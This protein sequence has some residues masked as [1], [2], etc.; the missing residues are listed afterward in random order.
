MRMK[1]VVSVKDKNLLYSLQ[2]VEDTFEI[3]ESEVDWQQTENQQRYTK[4]LFIGKGIDKEAL[5][6]HLQLAAVVDTSPS[7]T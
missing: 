3:I 2:G 1:G 4:L 7:S 6:S 5:R